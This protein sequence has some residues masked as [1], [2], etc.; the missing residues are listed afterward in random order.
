MRGVVWIVLKWMISQPLAHCE[1]SNE[2]QCER[3]GMDGAGSG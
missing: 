2:Y 3:C 1:L